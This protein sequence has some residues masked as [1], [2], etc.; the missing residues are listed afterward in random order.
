MEERNSRPR[1]EAHSISS[2]NSYRVGT[3]RTFKA[4]G[5]GCSLNL[6]SLLDR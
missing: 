5:G 6:Y 1:L 4:G 3:G 2:P